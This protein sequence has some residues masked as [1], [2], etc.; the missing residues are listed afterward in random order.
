MIL[1]SVSISE[2]KNQRT[3][4]GAHEETSDVHEVMRSIPSVRIPVLHRY[5]N[6]TAHVNGWGRRGGLLN[7]ITYPTLPIHYTIINSL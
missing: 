2:L 3:S 7:F 1:Y 5:D 4:V 6:S